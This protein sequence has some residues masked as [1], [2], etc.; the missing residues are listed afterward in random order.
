MCQLLKELR[1]EAK[2]RLFEFL[3]SP[4]DKMPNRET[5]YRDAMDEVERHETLN[6]LEF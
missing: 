3:F 6:V 2:E 1:S 5:L 4:Y